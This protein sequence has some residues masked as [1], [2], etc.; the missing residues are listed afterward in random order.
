MY[1]HRICCCKI[2]DSFCADMADAVSAIFY[3]NLSA[4]D[5]KQIILLFASH[6]FIPCAKL[7]HY[8]QEIQ[9]QNKTVTETSAPIRSLTSF[10]CQK[11]RM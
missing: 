8:L 10:L 3:V 9:K 5:K 6:I 7:Y 2:P 4:T 1:L 11:R